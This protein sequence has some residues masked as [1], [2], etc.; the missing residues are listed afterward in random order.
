MDSATLEVT[1]AKLVRD[2]NT[3]CYFGDTGATRGLG[4]VLG[5]SKTDEAEKGKREEGAGRD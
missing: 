3:Y 1:D 5:L 4:M 2:R